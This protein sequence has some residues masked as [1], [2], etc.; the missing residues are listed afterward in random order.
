MRCSAVFMLLCLGL[1]S[2]SPVKVDLIKGPVVVPG[3]SL[4]EQQTFL[5]DTCLKVTH[6]IY[7]RV[8][9]NQTEALIRLMLERAC[10][11]TQ[12]NRTAEC[13]QFVDQHID[14]LFAMIRAELSPERICTRLGLCTGYLSKRDEEL[15]KLDNEIAKLDQRFEKTVSD[16]KKFTEYVATIEMIDDVG[17]FD[18]TVECFICDS[19]VEASVEISSY[20]VDDIRPRYKVYTDVLDVCELLK[21]SMRAKM[22]ISCLQVH[23]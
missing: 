15:M 20:S 1:A 22:L 23:R 7:D 10:E 14:E 16:I 13:K 21:G 19:V 4:E 5:C 2:A 17:G 18:S 6:L 12:V 9:S 3:K 8:A 11:V